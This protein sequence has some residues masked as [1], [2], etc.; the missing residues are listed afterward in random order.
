MVIKVLVVCQPT[1]T[2][3]ICLR[4]TLYLRR[5]RMINRYLEEDGSTFIADKAKADFR[6]SAAEIVMD[7][8]A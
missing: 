8:D 7:L 3:A 1:L 5:L 6:E 4:L 2:G